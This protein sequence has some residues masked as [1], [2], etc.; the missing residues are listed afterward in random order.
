MSGTTGGIPGRSGRATDAENGASWTQNFD[1]VHDEVFLRYDVKFGD[2]FD[3]RAGGK[4]PGLFGGKRNTGG[5]KPTGN[6]GFSARIVWQSGGQMTTY[7]YHPDQAAGKFGDHYYWTGTETTV[8]EPHPS[9][10]VIRF[11]PGRW[12][13][14]EQHLTMNT[15]GRRDGV[16]EQWVDGLLA[17]RVTGL[18]LRQDNSF[19]IDGMYFNTFFGGQRDRYRTAK[20]ETVDFDNFMMSTRRPVVSATV[21]VGA[22]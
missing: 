16:L 7:L 13:T 17:T 15:P 11:V 4:L 12:Y 8:A 9:G 21:P 5:H 6:D 19:G 1:D 2:G 18:M 14:I 20:D 10:Q 3:F 22:E